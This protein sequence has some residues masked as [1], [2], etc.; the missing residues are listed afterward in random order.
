MFLVRIA[1]VLL[2]LAA[3]LRIRSGKA[4]LRTSAFFVVAAT[5]FKLA[6]VC[7]TLYWSFGFLVTNYIDC[8]RTETIQGKARYLCDYCP[9]EDCLQDIFEEIIPGVP[10][11]RHIS[12]HG[13][14]DGK[15]APEQ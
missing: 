5:M 1:I 11:V 10:I 6:I 15:F 9:E 3:F 12:Q 14:M 7:F 13:F 4:A 2:S 8:D